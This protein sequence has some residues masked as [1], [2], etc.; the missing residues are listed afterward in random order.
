MFFL[1]LSNEAEFC[2]IFRSKCADFYHPDDE[3]GIA[4]NDARIGIEWP[5]VLGEYK[6]TPSAKGYVMDGVALNVS[7]K[8]QKWESL[9]KI[10]T[11]FYE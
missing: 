8:D 11:D 2:C 10:S 3:G 1:V 9:E 7:D 4:W 5:N 6:G